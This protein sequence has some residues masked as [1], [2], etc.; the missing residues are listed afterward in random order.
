MSENKQNTSTQT[1]SPATA[2][3]IAR[4]L[5]S[6]G[7]EVTAIGSFIVSYTLSRDELV[8]LMIAAEE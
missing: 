6:A 7:F 4:K 3:F 1:D 2:D 8:D 5:R